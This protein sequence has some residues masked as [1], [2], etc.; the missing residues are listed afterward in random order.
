MYYQN[1]IYPHVPVTKDDLTLK[2][3]IKYSGMTLLDYQTI[4]EVED[5]I[6]YASKK[7]VMNYNQCSD[8]IRFI[9]SALSKE[10]TKLKYNLIPPYTTCRSDSAF[11][12]NTLVD[13][14]LL[15]DFSYSDISNSF[16]IEVN[17]QNSYSI[18]TLMNIGL[19]DFLLDGDTNVSE[20][21]FNVN[22]ISDFTST[23]I[24]VVFLKEK[25]LFFIHYEL[26]VGL[27][28]DISSHSNQ[29]EKLKYKIFKYKNHNLPV[30]EYYIVSSLVAELLPYSEKIVSI[31]SLKSL[32]STNLR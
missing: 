14:K 1:K 21:Y 7:L 2:D 9:S 29:L 25:K 32:K 15:S 8:I 26:A 16:F 24:D 12:L 31:D 19:C 5:E 30:E 28:A 11:I 10:E 3:Y 18:R 17:L 22:L 20:A 13:I 23:P 27:E 6:K 4:R